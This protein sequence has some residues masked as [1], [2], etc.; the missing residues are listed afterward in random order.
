MA[1]L[2]QTGQAVPVVPGGAGGHKVELIQHSGR[3]GNWR[4][5][6]PQDGLWLRHTVQQPV[7]QQLRTE[8]CLSRPPFAC[9]GPAQLV[10]SGVDGERHVVWSLRHAQVRWG[11]LGVLD[12]QPRHL[13][14]EVHHQRCGPVRGERGTGLPPRT[15]TA[16]KCAVECKAFGRLGHLVLQGGALYV[17]KDGRT[18]LTLCSFTGNMAKFGAGMATG[19]DQMITMQVRRSHSCCY[20]HP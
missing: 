18:N 17:E 4:G 19:R 6:L 13:A 10:G 12:N 15:K 5:H 11:N 3:D 1:T 9:R 7:L 8:V 2:P 20:A 16:P 14:N